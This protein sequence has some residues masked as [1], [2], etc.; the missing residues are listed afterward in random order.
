MERAVMLVSDDAFHPR[1]HTPTYLPT[2][3]SPGAYALDLEE[4]REREAFE[5]LRNVMYSSVFI[6][7]ILTVRLKN[8]KKKNGSYGKR[9]VFFARGVET[10]QNKTKRLG[11]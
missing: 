11:C 9:S 8:A 3:P 5:P 7:N 6:F 4:E 1:T 2:R 10:K